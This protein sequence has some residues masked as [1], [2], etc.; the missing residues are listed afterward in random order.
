[1]EF[2][3]KI[4]PGCFSRRWAAIVL[5]L[6]VVPHAGLAAG[7]VPVLDPMFI[8]IYGA[9]AAAPVSVSTATSAAS[10]SAGA[11]P[12]SQH[13]SLATHSIQDFVAANNQAVLAADAEDFQFRPRYVAVLQNGQNVALSGDQLNGYWSRDVYA[14]RTLAQIGDAEV[15]LLAGV[16]VAGFNQ[17]GP[18]TLDDA[19]S[20]A[21]I[22]VMPRLAGRGTLLGPMFGIAGGR[23]V[24]KHRIQG[25]FQQSMLYGETELSRAAADGEQ[26]SGSGLE[27]YV[28]RQNFN[29]AVSELG[30]KYLYELSD[31]VAFGMGAMASVWWG[32]SALANSTINSHDK[33]SVNLGGMGTLEVRFY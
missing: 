4:V 33:T 3:G 26:F 9:N 24:A 20:P 13:W 16:K 32:D 14:Q 5:A 2:A 31:R 15:Q 28:E 30:V 27:S 8:M 7:L 11:I 6:L 25:V 12:V 21:S 18:Q 19:S 23:T 29:V 22:A 17:S 10:L 1:M